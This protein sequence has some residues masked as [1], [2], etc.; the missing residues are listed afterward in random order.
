MTGFKKFLKIS[1]QVLGTALLAIRDNLLDVAV[2]LVCQQANRSLKAVVAPA[3]PGNPWASSRLA[4]RT[5]DGLVL[6]GGQGWQKLAI[7]KGLPTPGTK[8]KTMGVENEPHHVDGFDGVIASGYGKGTKKLLLDDAVMV[9]VAGKSSLRRANYHEHNADRAGLHYD[10]AIEGV[11]ENT[12]LYEFHVFRGPLKGRYAV[13]RTDKGMLIQNMKDNGQQ[14]AKPKTSLRDVSFLESIEA[15]RA[16]WSVTRKYDGS[17][18]SATFVH[19][20]SAF[21]GHR[22][23]SQTY[24]DRLPALEFVDNKSPYLTCRS[25]FK[26][27]NQEGTMLIGEIVHSDGAARV[28]GLLNAHP[29]KSQSI[30]KLRG[31]AEFYAWDIERLRGKDVSGLPQWKREELYTEVIA[32]LRRFNKAYHVAERAPDSLSFREYYEQVLGDALPWGEGV[33]AKHKY[34][35]DRNWIKI[36]RSDTVD[37]VVTGFTEGKG[38]Y[39]GSLGVLEVVGPTGEYGKVGSFSITDEQRDWIWTNRDL[40]IGEVAEIEAFEMTPGREVPRA[41]RF[42][43]WHASKSEASLI[44]YAETVTGDMD[45]QSTLSTKYALIQSARGRY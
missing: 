12:S 10:L 36:K 4:A 22:D 17:S 20:R 33:V 8:E 1:D 45:R 44:M 31:E 9:K 26:G 6:E 39:A 24:Y 16:N 28:G 11:P 34:S 18:S 29:D 14:F 27:P 19:N 37:L 21:R 7:R 30:Q 13:I 23:E 40:L 32:D 3:S 25:L 41:G 2:S 5:V 38:K 35:V 43:R 15:D 42:I